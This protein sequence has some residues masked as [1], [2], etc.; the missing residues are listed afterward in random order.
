M[1]KQVL[2]TGKTTVSVCRDTFKDDSNQDVEY[3]FLEIPVDDELG[4]SE[5][6]KFKSQS[7]YASLARNITKST[8]TMKISKPT[9]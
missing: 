2:A 3:L 4:I 5:R 7:A 6:A 1:A 8:T 9:E